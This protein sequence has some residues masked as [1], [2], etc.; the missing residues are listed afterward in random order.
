VG[1]NPQARARAMQ[2]VEQF[3]GAQKMIARPSR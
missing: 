3:F 2:A 1:P